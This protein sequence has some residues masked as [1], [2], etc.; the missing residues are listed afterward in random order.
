[1]EGL[2]NTHVLYMVN[3]KLYKYSEAWPINKSFKC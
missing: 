3:K 1:M 2:D